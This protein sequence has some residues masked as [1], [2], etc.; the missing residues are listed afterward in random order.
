MLLLTKIRSNSEVRQ[1][2]AI[3][4]EEATK[5]TVILVLELFSPD[6]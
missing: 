3:N 5:V 2:A 1:D 4:K 6:T